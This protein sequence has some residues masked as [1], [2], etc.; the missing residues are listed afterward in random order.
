MNRKDF[1]Y[2]P[3]YYE[4]LSI[5]ESMGKQNH[6]LFEFLAEN[7]LAQKWNDFMTKKLKE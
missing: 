7:G 1:S 2:L 4:L 6:D 5:V 3:Y